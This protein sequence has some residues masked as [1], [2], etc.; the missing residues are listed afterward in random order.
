MPAREDLQGTVERLT[1][2]LDSISEIFYTVDHAWRF[3]YL[4]PPAARYFGRPQEALLGQN[5]WDALPPAVGSVFDTNYHRAMAVGTP[6]RFEAQSPLT[7]R[8]VEVHVYPS[9]AGLAAFLHDITERKQAE[10][11][12]R[13]AYTVLQQRIQ[14]R[15]A[16]LQTTDAALRL[17][18]TERQHAEA[19]QRRL[20][21]ETRRAE[22]FALLGRLAAGVAHEI[23]NPLGAIVLHVDLLEEELHAPSPQSPAEMRQALTEIK[24]QL[25]RL[26]DLLQDYL[27]LARVATIEHTT[28]DLGITVQAWAQEWQDRIA[29]RGVRLQLVGLADLGHAVFHRG[30]LRRVVLNLVQNAVDAM[31]Q[32]G[33]LTLAGQ[34][35]ATQVQLHV[36]DTG[37]GIPVE[38]LAHIFEPLYTTKPEGTGLGLYIVQ[39]IMAAHAGHVTVES[40]LGQGTT[41]TLTLP[42]A[43]D[44]TPVGAP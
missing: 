26:D 33:T 12:L 36:R 35:T 8:W 24:T 22:H 13:H 11:A 39:E 18:I 43:V 19:E 6:V 1:T 32:G 27:S 20:E 14:E 41:F 29:A 40:A 37:S 34:R 30:T 7:G 25:A 23:R 16:D 38:Q 4:N 10:E 3:T 21:D 31:P 28:Q 2:I 42:H 17:A 15:T 44:A 9:A 5:L